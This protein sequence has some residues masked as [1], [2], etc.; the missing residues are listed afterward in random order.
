MIASLVIVI[1]L[2]AA[3]VSGKIYFKEDFQSKDW[4]KRWTV[5]SKWKPK[6]GLNI[7]HIAL[8]HI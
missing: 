7:T 8:N 4:E 1:T 2:I 5:P 6:V 3:F